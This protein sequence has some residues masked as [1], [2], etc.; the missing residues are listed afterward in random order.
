Q[1]HLAGMMT[2]AD[3]YLDKPLNPHQLV[4]AI[5]HT[6][7]IAPRQRLDRLRALGEA[8][9]HQAAGESEPADE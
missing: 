8:D 6:V 4:A 5:R 1:D 2:G 7:E 9:D 3:V